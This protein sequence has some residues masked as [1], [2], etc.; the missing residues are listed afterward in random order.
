M[1]YKKGHNLRKFTNKLLESELQKAKDCLLELL[2]ITKQH[3]ELTMQ[4][5]E[6]ALYLIAEGVGKEVLGTRG[7]TFPHKLPKRRSCGK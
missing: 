2:R 4:E 3:R 5:T 7:D 6:V 1:A